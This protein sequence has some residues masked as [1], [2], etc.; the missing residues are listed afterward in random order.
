MFD[1]QHIYFCCRLRLMSKYCYL[2]VL[3]EAH[4]P[5]CQALVAQHPGPVRQTL[6]AAFPAGGS[7]RPDAL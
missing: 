5:A 3:A 6:T 1:N 7:G 4:S 2:Q